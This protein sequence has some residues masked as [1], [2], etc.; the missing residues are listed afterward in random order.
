MQ[1]HVLKDDP[2]PALEVLKAGGRVVCFSTHDKDL[3]NYLGCTISIGAE[4]EFEENPEFP[5]VK[6]Y[7]KVSGDRTSFYSLSA[8][9][10]GGGTPILRS[11]S[12]VVGA[13]ECIG[14]G[15][16]WILPSL[17]YSSFRD[18]GKN[19]FVREVFLKDTS[20]A[21]LHADRTEVCRPDWKRYPL[22]VS[23]DGRH[24]GPLSSGGLRT[25]ALLGQQVDPL[26]YGALKGFARNPGSGGS[27]LV[28]DCP[29]GNLPPTPSVPGGYTGKDCVSEI[30]L[31]T[32]AS[33]VGH[34][35]GYRPEMGGR[36]VQDIVPT[37]KDSNEQTSTSSLTDLYYHTEAVFHPYRPR[38]LALLCLRGDPSART[39]ICNVYDIVSALSEDVCEVL[40]TSEFVTGV[41]TSYVRGGSV[42]LSAPHKV[43]DGTPNRPRISWDWSLT[44]GVSERA[45]Q[46]LHALKAAVREVQSF[47]V[48][49]AGDLLLIDNT[50]LVHGRSSFTPRFDG[51]DR[52]LQ[53]ALILADTNIPHDTFTEDVVGL[54][55]L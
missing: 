32:I 48:L 51:T 16:L 8:R 9:V 17:E 7:V 6:G 22:T 23:L 25:S 15:E 1:V 2:V 4:S 12:G 30:S 21:G 40:H 34:P 3:L 50:I 19:L 33:I 52:W 41:D 39:T 37:K 5:H 42:A 24:A 54:E 20:P 44:S 47:L 27:L 35:V 31:M 14:S 13:K 43:L 28:R 26:L 18:R 46:A 29:L 45:R 36:I 49:G 53:R 11:S 55:F 10:L 38:W